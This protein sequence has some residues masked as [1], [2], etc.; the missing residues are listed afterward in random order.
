M[1]NLNGVLAVLQFFGAA[2]AIEWKIEWLFWWC[3]FWC[4]FSTGIVLCL[5]E[6]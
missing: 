5:K 6:E 2:L 3:T 1:R 4:I